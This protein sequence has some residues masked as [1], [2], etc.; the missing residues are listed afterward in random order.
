MIRFSQFV[1]DRRAGTLLRG[2]EE[3]RL[4]P[5]TWAVLCHLAERPGVVVSRE[6]LFGSLWSD[7][8]VS[9]GTLSNSI[10]ELRAALG[11]DSRSPRFIE[12]VH[13]RGYR[14]VAD[15]AGAAA[16]PPFSETASQRRGQGARPAA[17]VGRRVELAALE[18]LAE[19]A[20]GGSTRAVL[21]RG[22]AGI[23]KTTLVGRLA[24]ALAARVD[25]DGVRVATGR[26]VGYLQGAPPFL[27]IVAALE[28]L[29]SGDDGA[30]VVHALREHAP[31]LIPP[32]PWPGDAAE[33]ATVVPA[34]R[35]LAPRFTDVL[36]AIAATRPVVLVLEDLHDADAPTVDWLSSLVHDDRDL[37]LLVVAT[38]RPREAA[39]ARNGLPAAAAAIEASPRG[40]SID[41]ELLGRR[42]VEEYLQQ[43]G[44][45]T[46]SRPLAESIHRRSGGNPLFMVTVADTIELLGGDAGEIPE[47]LRGLL[48]VQLRALDF[49]QR[50]VLVAAAAVGVEFS[51]PAVA[52]AT[53]QPLEVVEPILDSLASRSRFLDPAGSAGWPSGI[54]GKAYSF[55]HGLYREA[56][57]AA[58]PA[59]RRRVLHQRIGEALERDYGGRTPEIA[60]QL[61]DHFSSSGDA[62]RA[63]RYLRQAAKVA[64]ERFAHREALDLLDRALVIADELPDA[65]AREAAEFS[66]H[67]DRAASAGALYGHGSSVARE[68]C[69]RVA[70]LGARLP[71]SLDRYFSLLVLFGYRIIRSDVAEATAIA[72]QL[73]RMAEVLG[74]PLPRLGATSASAMAAYQRGDFEAAERG[75]RAVVAG[76]P[77]DYRLASFRDVLCPS[78]TVMAET[79]CYLDRPAEAEPFV[80][81]GRERADWLGDAF[82]RASSRVASASCAAISGDRAGTRRWAQEAWDLSREH[83]ID[84]TLGQAAVL[85]AWADEG[86]GLDERT[87]RATEALRG[88]ER[89]GRLLGRGFHLG[90]LADLQAEAGDLSSAAS[91]LRSAREFCESTG[92]LRHLA[93]LCHRTA[94]VEARLGADGAPAR[95]RHWRQQAARIA[96]RQRCALVLRL[97]AEDH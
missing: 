59:N 80:A 92:S 95:S 67:G 6:E 72:E 13:R 74:Q 94:Q 46:W 15:V 85:A 63:V 50:E 42:E 32:M 88:L 93:P 23:G 86:A 34:G 2:N 87:R 69:E 31:G 84:E 20:A 40:A 43:R 27:P 24:A 37:R 18:R 41:L 39:L 91:T 81:R 62:R 78:L 83:A 73:V 36:A 12:T 3:V 28:Q 79:L 58:L 19:A 57:H 45:T 90:L 22:E 35:E 97:L 9:E 47:S 53:Q 25:L 54:E 4:R 38:Y 75:L 70:E 14:F 76:V 21:V 96:G 68:A 82:E 16:K 60:A 71:A 1:L 17:M 89:S 77:S 48:E 49:E 51:S 56:L 52:A 55:R 44:S 61:A 26:A 30:S 11:D 33:P 29:A 66:L 8:V 5:R 64:R 65:A 7:A 10:R